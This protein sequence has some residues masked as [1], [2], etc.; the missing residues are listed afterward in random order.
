VKIHMY[1]VLSAYQILHQLQVYFHLDPP[2][3]PSFCLI[4]LLYL[5]LQLM[6]T[7]VREKKTSQIPP[8]LPPGKYSRT[9]LKWTL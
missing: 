8:K 4:M 9:C 5:L 1:F 3:V 7:K 2:C 6:T